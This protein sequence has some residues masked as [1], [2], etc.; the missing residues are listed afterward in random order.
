MFFT[1]AVTMFIIAG[2]CI[3]FLTR[4]NREIAGGTDKEDRVA[5]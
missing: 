5:A 1:F 3:Y 4:R 2:A